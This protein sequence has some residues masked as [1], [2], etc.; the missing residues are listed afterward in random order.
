MSHPSSW[1]FQSSNQQATPLPDVLACG[2]RW[3]DMY[4]FDAL[5]GTHLTHLRPHKVRPVCVICVLQLMHRRQESHSRPRALAALEG[6]AHLYALQALPL[7]RRSTAILHRLCVRRTLFCVHASL[8]ASA[9]R[10][11]VAQRARADDDV[12]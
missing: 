6:R 11:A 5:K 10:H 4:V 1:A 12:H 9:L 3:G 2:N 7:C 8:C